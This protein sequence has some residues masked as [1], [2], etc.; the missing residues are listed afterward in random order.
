[1][2]TIFGELTVMFWSSREID[3]Y[4]IGI[5]KYACEKHKFQKL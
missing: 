5:N 1:M 4:K 2:V 3:V